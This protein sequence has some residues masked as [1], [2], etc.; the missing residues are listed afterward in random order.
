MA[1][2][3]SFIRFSP[4][5]HVGP[6]RQV[7]SHTHRRLCVSGVA[8]ESVLRVTAGP[9][10]CL[11]AFGPLEA[12][13]M[14]SALAAMSSFGPY[15]L[16]GVVWLL[17][18]RRFSSSH[19]QRE[20]WVLHGQ[21]WLPHV[22]QAAGPPTR[23]ISMFWCPGVPDT[24]FSLEPLLPVG[25]YSALC[26][27]LPLPVCF[28]F[29]ASTA[30]RALILNI[31]LVSCQLD[32]LSPPPMCS[33]YFI[34]TEALRYIARVRPPHS[35]HYQR[36]PAPRPRSGSVDPVTELVASQVSIVNAVSC[37]SSNHA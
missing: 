31:L 20:A 19:T 27:P 3:V 36:S 6:A 33:T 9:V 26:V 22:L 1:F 7:L 17:H 29:P 34:Q 37:H 11:H 24:S 12:P 14:P 10:R 15:P 8:A 18:S 16:T 4:F 35:H 5:I 32:T 13:P 2:F 30:P 25:C 28:S 23:H 21:D